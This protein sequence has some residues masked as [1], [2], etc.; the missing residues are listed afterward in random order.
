MEANQIRM[1]GCRTVFESC[2]QRKVQKTMLVRKFV[3]DLIEKSI[4]D[5]YYAARELAYDYH[6]F[7]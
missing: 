5:E 4:P 1:R 7:G 2:N 3:K 6:P